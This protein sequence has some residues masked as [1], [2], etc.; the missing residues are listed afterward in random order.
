MIT[1]K[2]DAE[3]G[4]MRAAGQVAARILKKLEDQSLPLVSTLALN[5]IA[6]DEIKKTGMKPGFKTVDNYQFAICTTINNEVVHGLPSENQL[7]AGDLL[8]IDLGVM[9]EGLHTDV[10]TSF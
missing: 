2:T 7:K 9:N 10:A 8:S 6:E 1:L 3:I 5:K 4:K